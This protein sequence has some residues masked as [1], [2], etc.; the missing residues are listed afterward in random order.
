MAQNGRPS[1]SEIWCESNSDN[2]ASVM[3]KHTIAGHRRLDRIASSVMNNIRK[4]AAAITRAVYGPDGG[5]GQIRCSGS[6]SRLV[7]GSNRL[8]KVATS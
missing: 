5:G 1:G 7:C 3:M 2:A 4:M 6:G 8:R